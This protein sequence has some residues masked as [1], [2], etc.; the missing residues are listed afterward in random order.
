M[1][2]HLQP[3]IELLERRCVDC[4]RWYAT[5]RA[6]EWVCGSCEHG[7]VAKLA[8]RIAKLERANAALRGAIGRKARA[9]KV[10]R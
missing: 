10:G 4:H 9:K 3:N 5:E 6:S 8:E 2:F 1:T 7:Y